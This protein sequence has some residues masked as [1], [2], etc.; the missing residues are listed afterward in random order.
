MRG[1]WRVGSKRPGGRSASIWIEF[2]QLFFERCF[3]P[4][5]HVDLTVPQDLRIQMVSKIH[6]GQ[7][8]RKERVQ[9]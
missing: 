1:R 2:S 7:T 6:L 4:D 9:V 5:N 3:F 8:S